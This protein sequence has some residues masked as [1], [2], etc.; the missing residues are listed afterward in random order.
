MTS[1]LLSCCHL[2]S[3]RERLGTNGMIFVYLRQGEDSITNEQWY[4]AMVN[5]IR[6]EFTSVMADFPSS[7]IERISGSLTR[8]LSDVIINWHAQRARRKMYWSLQPC[9]TSYV[10]SWYFENIK[11]DAMEPE[12]ITNIIY[13]EATR[14]CIARDRRQNRKCAGYAPCS[15]C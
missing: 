15:W 1:Q 10:D 11:N 7:A 9:Q 14:V 8:L 2:K 3:Y 13:F 5:I 12:E 6:V 4:L